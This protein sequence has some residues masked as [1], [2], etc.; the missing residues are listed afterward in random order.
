MRLHVGRILLVRKFTFALPFK[1]L[2]I[3]LKIFLSL[4]VFFEDGKYVTKLMKM[5]VFN[6]WLIILCKIK[7]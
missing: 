1:Y 6:F 3:V 7:C 5:W 2:P 4:Q